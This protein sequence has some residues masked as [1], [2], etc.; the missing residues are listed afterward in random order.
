[1]GPDFVPSPA[2]LSE[3]M[4]VLGPVGL[5][6]VTLGAMLLYYGIRRAP[7]AA[8]DKP[9][10]VGIQALLAD[11]FAMERFITGLN[12]LADAQEDVAKALNR[13]ADMADIARAVERLRPHD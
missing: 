12:R 7:P 13:M 8:H 3:A 11:Q 6:V 5:G 9:P 10:Q 4:Q 1:M 2:T